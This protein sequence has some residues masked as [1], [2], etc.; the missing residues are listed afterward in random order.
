MLETTFGKKNNIIIGVIHLPAMMGYP[1]FTGYDIALA[2]AL[3]DLKA[4]EQGGADA[5]IVENNYDIPHVI[6]VSGAAAISMCH[7]AQQIRAATKLP[8]G[9]SVLWNDYKTAFAMAV[10]AGYQFIRIPVFVDKVK[11]DYGI[12]EGNPQEVLAFRKMV[13]ANNVKILVDIHVKHAEILMGCDQVTSGQRAMAQGADGVI[14][15]G[16]WT[17]DPPDQEAVKILREG[18]GDAPI[19]VGSGVSAQ[20]VA[21]LFQYANGAIVSTSLKEDAAPTHD[22]NVKGYDVR[23]SE[24]KVRD[25]VGQANP[26]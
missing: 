6:D 21:G 24:R 9:I 14:V 17:G 20:N 4:F 26:K 12:M 22:R 10:T 25:L 13:G 23:V 1:E 19:F 16:K 15:T 3:K 18:L 2:N 5:V 7:L 11:T 8:L